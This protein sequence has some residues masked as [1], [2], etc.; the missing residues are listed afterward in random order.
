MSTA[1]VDFTRGAAERIARVVRTVEQGSRDESPL[2][3]SVVETP[4]K[5]FRVC[6]FTGAWP[7]NSSKT[8]TFRN[9][10]STP[11]T[12]TAVNLFASIAEPTGTASCAIARDGSAWYV[13]AAQCS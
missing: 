5:V 8:V 13:I 6:R 4:G 2:T 1:R 7:I 3:F 12:V 10:T 11:N 9:K